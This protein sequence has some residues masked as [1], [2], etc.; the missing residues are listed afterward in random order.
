MSIEIGKSFK[1]I[2]KQ[3]IKNFVYNRLLE[4][5]KYTLAA[6]AKKYN[7]EY[8]TKMS[9]DEIVDLIRKSK[10]ID[11]W[12]IY[13]TN[14]RYA[15]GLHPSGLEELLNID[16]KQR[17][18]L[19]KN[20][21]IKIAYTKETKTS[22]GRIDVP[23]YDLE[24]LY[25]IKKTDMDA[26]IEKYKSRQ[27]TKKQLDA[28][29]KARAK[30]EENI[31]CVVCGNK[32]SKAFLSKDRICPS[33]RESIEE[34]IAFNAVIDEINAIRENKNDYLI[35]HCETSGLG[36]NDVIISACI[37]D[38]EGNIIIDTLLKSD[39]YTISADATARHGIKQE[40]VNIYGITKEEF[41]SK[42]G[43]LLQQ[44]TIIIW[45]IE[46]LKDKIKNF[47]GENTLN[48]KNS[49]K[50]FAQLAGEWN[51]YIKNDI[52]TSVHNIRRA[53]DIKIDSDSYTSDGCEKV[54]QLLMYDKWS[55]RKIPD[56]CIE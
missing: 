30:A 55:H 14:K 42:V 24:C 38:L 41:L 9:K 47:I 3:Y 51:Y 5:D 22:F 44:K 25:K 39:G 27:A 12:D 49:Y 32:W 54:L 19:V 2:N 10:G 56:V 35:M 20:N 48:F 23:M 43:K 16:K 36:S 31:T 28:L 40:D 50:I 21:I 4:L 15:F 45:N 13:I 8:K 6:I 53:R 7:L 33:C 1:V 29:K 52:W 26:Y 17:T 34:D 37:I 18:K 46:F 11:Y